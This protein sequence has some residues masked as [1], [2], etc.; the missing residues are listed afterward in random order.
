MF[1]AISV[2]VTFFVMSYF[3]TFIVFGNALPITS[4]AQLVCFSLGLL[5]VLA[6]SLLAPC[7]QIKVALFLWAL[8]VVLAT[9]VLGFQFFSGWS[10]T[11][12]GGGVAVAFIAWWMNPVRS[13]HES[14]RATIGIGVT[15]LAVL[16]LLQAHLI[17][18]PAQP[19]DIK[20]DLG[21][22]LDSDGAG[23]E[24]AYYYSLGGIAM[25]SERLWRI[26]ADSKTISQ[27]INNLELSS[28][29]AVPD[30]FWNMQPYY[31]PRSMPSS[32]ESFQSS[33]FLQMADGEH[34]FLLHDKTQ[35]RAYVWIENNF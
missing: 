18:L 20:S 17:D 34:Y 8:S 1:E 29:P 33:K 15:L 25:G 2:V 10:S 6:G 26:D 32:G 11:L 24:A 16:G 22:A 19:D 31:W 3:T 5:V 9:S 7:Y 30:K 28:T 14:R 12:A 35:G 4:S 23:V 27:L 21:W 13:P